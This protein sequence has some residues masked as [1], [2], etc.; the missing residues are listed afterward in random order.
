MTVQELAREKI[1]RLRGQLHSHGLCFSAA[2]SLNPIWVIVGEH[3]QAPEEEQDPK[4]FATQLLLSYKILGALSATSNRHEHF[5]RGAL[6]RCFSGY[7][8]ERIH[9]KDPNLGPRL[10]LCTIY[11]LDLYDYEQNIVNDILVKA[12]TK[13]EKIIAQA[14]VEGNVE[15]IKMP[16]QVRLSEKM[17]QIL[18]GSLSASHGVILPEKP[19]ADGT[20]EITYLPG[21]TGTDIVELVVAAGKKIKI[22]DGILCIDLTSL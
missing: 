17:F 15:K 9:N 1:I 2:D 12:Q 3:E 7:D 5:I 8:A 4:T 6:V 20:Y 13:V 10:F 11:T 16:V 14:I 19:E 18:Q 22:T 21:S